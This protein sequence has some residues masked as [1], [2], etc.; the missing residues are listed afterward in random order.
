MSSYL[1][2]SSVQ[3]IIKTIKIKNFCVRSFL[4]AYEFYIKN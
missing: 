4:D 3:K 2:F 1:A